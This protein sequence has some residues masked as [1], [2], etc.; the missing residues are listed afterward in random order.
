V[1]GMLAH[2]QSLAAGG[3]LEKRTPLLLTAHAE[4]GSALAQASEESLTLLFSGFESFLIDQLR[5]RLAKG[6]P[7]KYGSKRSENERI[8]IPAQ[9]GD[10][11]GKFFWKIAGYKDAKVTEKLVGERIETWQRVCR[12]RG[13]DDEA[14]VM[15]ETLVECYL[16]ENKGGNP[17]EFL[18][19]VGRRTGLIYP[20]F[21]GRSA[22]KRIRPSVE[23]LEVLVKA[24]T[25]TSSP[26][27]DSVFLDE[28]WNTFG[29]VTGG[30]PDDALI[31]EEAGIHVS[32]EE[33]SSNWDSLVSRLADIGLARRYPDNISYVGRFHA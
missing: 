17:K 4:K 1:L 29:F 13:K 9:R 21:E 32:F 22:Q 6:E 14:F 10:S 23:I 5:D 18:Q 33:L 25:P 20:H 19:G 31:L 11:I 15:A 24:C 16:S 28:L 26:V 8:E 2:A 27:S 30:R 12:V 7:V 3:D